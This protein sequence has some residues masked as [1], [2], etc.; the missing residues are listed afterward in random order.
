MWKEIETELLVA[1]EAGSLI[2]RRPNFVKLVAGLYS[3][4]LFGLENGRIMRASY[5]PVRF[6]DDLL[7]GDA[8]FNGDPLL[9]VLELK[10][11]IKS[12]SLPKTRVEK[13]LKYAIDNLESRARNDD[14]PR[15]DFV[16]SIDSIIF[17]YHRAK[18]RRVLTFSEIQDYYKMAFD[19]VINITLMASGSSIRSKEV[20]TLSYGQGRVYS[21]RDIRTDWQ[22]GIINIPKEVLDKCNLT[23]YS[24][25]NE[26]QNNQILKKWTTISLQQT[27]PDLINTQ[28]FLKNLGEKQTF[29]ICNSLISPMLKFIGSDKI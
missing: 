9:Y 11:N 10:E 8:K 18:E 27:K 14:D 20:P 21:A 5:L 25:L 23:S 12:N 26:I 13:Q 24:S 7:D 16:K 15:G 2:Y 3:L 22:R 17:D 6:V 28:S 19:P 1:K 4:S 29:L